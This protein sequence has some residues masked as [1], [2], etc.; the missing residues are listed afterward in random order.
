MSDSHRKLLVRS[1]LVTATGVLVIVALVVFSPS[2]A[3]TDYRPSG[4]PR[5]LPSEQLAA[6][7]A[8]DFAGILLGL[9]GDP[10]VVNVWASWCPPCRAEM[11]LL[12]RAADEYAGRVRFIGV[13]S[14]DSRGAAGDFLEEIGVDYP[15]VFDTSGDVGPDLGLRGF[16][17]TYLFDRESVLREAVVGGITEQRLA[18]QLED[19]MR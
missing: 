19:L 4:A 5:A 2:D 10:V 6:V 18:A 3:T 1:L 17:T 16:P 14:K 13:A 8:A 7:S 9:R 15:N 11:P 12:D